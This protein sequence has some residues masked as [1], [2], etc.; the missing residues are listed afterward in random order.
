MAD[1]LGP[2]E[3]KDL[4]RNQ[5]MEAAAM[6]V[7][8]VRRRAQ[9]FDEKLRRGALGTRVLLLFLAIGYS[10]FLYFFPGTVQRIGSGI[11]LA[12]FAYAAYD[13]RRRFPSG[14]AAAGPA[15]VTSAA[16][17][18]ELERHREYVLRLWMR[19]LAYV[20]GPVVF[21]M[22]FAAE[23]LGPMK[24]VALAI[25][26]ILAPFVALVPATAIG[27]RKLQWEIDELDRMVKQS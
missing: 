4:W 23:E 12:G 1:E 9:R 24:A 18:A 10:S 2:E 22:G 14:K 3:M 17:R 15:S 25:A 7:E 11:T 13:T 27:A 21:I 26:L 19:M 5:P 16:Y 20:P 6:A 8:E